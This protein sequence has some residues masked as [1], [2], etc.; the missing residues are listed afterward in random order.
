MPLQAQCNC[1]VRM[2]TFY[3]WKPYS[4][5]YWNN[6]ET[7]ALTMELRAWIEVTQYHWYYC[8]EKISEK[9][10]N[11]DENRKSEVF[12]YFS[13]ASRHVTNQ[14]AMP[15]QAWCNC[16]VRMNT[17][18][19][20]KLYSDIYL[21]NLETIALPM[22]LR[23]WIMGTQYHWHNCKEKISERWRNIGENR[24]GEVAW[25]FFICT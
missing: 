14:V 15:L 1:N 18:Y 17:F 5:I 25:V 12:R 10:R 6:S 20:L 8:K 7:I 21:N 9:W 22:E 19:T 2:N 23:A 24:K 3:A 16:N 4:D 13:F 11:V